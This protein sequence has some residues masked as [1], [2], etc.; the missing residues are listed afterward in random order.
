[1]N[2]DWDAR[3]V[4][5]FKRA[6][7]AS[8]RTIRSLSDETGI[9]YRSLQ[10]YFSGTSKMPAGVLLKLCQELSINSDYLA[11]GTF[12]LPH[13]TLRDA[14]YRSLGEAAF[15]G[16]PTNTPL[17]MAKLNRDQERAL[18]EATKR[19][20]NAIDALSV[21]WVG[22]LGYEVMNAE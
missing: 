22:E 9:P 18:E 12:Q 20:N 21:A 15:H 1:M 11:H 17:R 10:N 16:K 6:L 5:G 14:L 13:T 7:A 4:D 8:G 3:V 19:L 2:E